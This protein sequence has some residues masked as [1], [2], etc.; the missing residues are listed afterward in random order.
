MALVIIVIGLPGSGKSKFCENLHN[1]DNYIIFDDFITY[2]Y[3]DS[4]I[5]QL[6]TL[7]DTKHKVCLAD[8]RLCM[9]DIFTKYIKIILKYVN[10]SNIQ[11]VLFENNPDMCIFNA[12][13]RNDNKRNIVNTIKK[14]SE[15]YVLDNYEDYNFLEMPVYSSINTQ[16]VLKK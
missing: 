9:Y 1:T 13:R 14:Y 3:N 8:P 16:I 11:L 12:E 15:K 5:D 10:K 7:N 2:F 4:V 6:K